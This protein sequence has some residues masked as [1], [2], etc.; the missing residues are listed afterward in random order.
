MSPPWKISCSLLFSVCD[1]SFRLFFTLQG[2]L[3]VRGTLFSY[4]R[5]LG[6]RNEKGGSGAV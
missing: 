1:S 2:G 6:P 4:P 5:L 3:C